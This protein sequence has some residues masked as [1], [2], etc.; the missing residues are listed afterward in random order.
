MRKQLIVLVAMIAMVS[1]C[2]KKQQGSSSEDLASNPLVNPQ[3]TYMNAPDFDKITV[4][5]FVPAFEE[6]M[7]QHNAEI[8]SIVNNSEAPTFANTIEALER[9]SEERRVGKEC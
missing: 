1:A 6:G 4:E 5:H 2:G 9:R 8:D 7:R 3:E